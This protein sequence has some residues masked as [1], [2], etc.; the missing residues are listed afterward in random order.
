MRSQSPARPIERIGRRLVAKNSK[1]RLFFDHLADSKG[2]EVADYLV[3]APMESRSDHVSG[4]TVLPVFDDQL[5]LLQS[6][7]HP[8]DSHIWEGVR[9]FVDVGEDPC[10]AAL[11]ELEEETGLLCRDEDLVRLGYCFPE[12]STIAGRAALFAATSCRPGGTRDDTELG[13]GAARSFT[14]PEIEILLENNEIEDATTEI[15]LRR[16]LNYT[17]SK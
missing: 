9:G 15:S 7:R 3:V 4:I 14:R 1:W 6:F 12:S 10:V 16:Y 2:N 13:L 11:R 8:V 5:I 17:S